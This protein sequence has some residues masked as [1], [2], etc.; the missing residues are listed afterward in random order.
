[1]ISKRAQSVGLV[2]E[3]PDETVI[4]GE[5]LNSLTAASAYLL[6]LKQCLSE[7]SPHNHVDAVHNAIAQCD[8]ACA[9]ARLLRSLRG[10]QVASS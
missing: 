9:A 1:M 4:L 2:A 8:R 6:G 10:K 5:L 7:N 3:R